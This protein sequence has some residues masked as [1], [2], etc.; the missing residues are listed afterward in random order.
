MKNYRI[1]AG[2]LFLLLVASTGFS[3]WR[4]TRAAGDEITVCVKKDGIVHVIGEGFKRADCK[5]NESLLSWNT[6]GVQGPKGDE[7]EQ[8]LKGDKG[9]QGSMGERGPAGLNLHLFDGNGQDLGI[10]IN[11][12]AGGY[13]TF[14]KDL[15]SIFHFAARSYSSGRGGALEPGNADLYFEQV[16]CRGIPFTAIGEQVQ[17][18]LRYS[19]QPLFPQY[20]MYDLS[21]V[22]KIRDF[23]SQAVGDRCAPNKG[24]IINSVMLREVSLPF[25]QPLAWPL[26]IKSTGQ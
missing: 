23:Q 15:G 1:I 19:P 2:V 22:P 11:Y 20:W 7:G 4:Y 9:D 26:V 14:N 17:D 10:L 25:S 5:K 8:G 21:E 6:E 3:V 13:I 16:D 18:V 12:F 24:T